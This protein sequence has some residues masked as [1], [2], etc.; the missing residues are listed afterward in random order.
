ME[1]ANIE[2]RRGIGLRGAIALNMTDMIGVGP[3]ITLPLIVQAMGGPQ[4]LIGWVAGAGFA[5]CDGLVWAE[6]GAAMPAAGGTYHYLREIYGRESWGKFISFLFLWQMLF[7]APLLMA[8]GCIGMAL[9]ATYL[10]PGL[11]A[12]WL[13]MAASLVALAL[14]YRQSTWISRIS[15]WLWAGVLL[16]VALVIVAGVT[17]FN[18]QRAFALPPHAFQFSSGFFIGLGSAMLI[19]TYDYW[20]YEN[21]NFVA[22]EI[23]HPERNLPRAIL[24]SIVVVGALYTVMNISVL[25]VI[26]WQELTAAGQH[27]IQSFV[28]SVFM[29]RLYGATA[30]A[31][32]TVL[33]IWTAFASVFSL[34]VGY[35]RVLYAAAAD[36]NFLS[37]F[38]HLNSDGRFPDVALVALGLA[39]AACCWFPLEAV[40]TALVVISVLLKYLLQAVGLILLRRRRPDLPRPFRMPAYPAPAIVAIAGFLFLLFAPAGAARE[41][42]YALL[43]LAAG[44]AVYYLRGRLDS[45]A[46]ARL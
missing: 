2:L 1:H 31:V 30:A 33:I 22:S 35:S 42:G 21:A 41:L 25:G 23:I 9:Y 44:A 14:A 10:W 11:H 32:V 19:A 6:L 15:Q 38:A 27:P 18:P 3:F 43:I 28:V 34:L 36:G 24:I 16:T 29:E 5:L 4:A 20:G 12:A 7:S 45:R 26:P 46:R 13:A 39:T 8:S 37:A 17:H 40:I